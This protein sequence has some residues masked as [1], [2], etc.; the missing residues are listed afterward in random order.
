MKYGR[1]NLDERIELPFRMLEDVELRY[2]DKCIFETDGTTPCLLEL[3][4]THQTN[5]D[6]VSENKYNDDYEKDI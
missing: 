3:D 2:N 6:G 4:N 5:D 1:D